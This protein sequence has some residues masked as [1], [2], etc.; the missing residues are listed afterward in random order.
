M[1]AD[2]VIV[3]EP[4]PGFRERHP[5]SHLSPVE[6]PGVAGKEAWV[7]ILGSSLETVSLDINYCHLAAASRTV[8]D[9]TSVVVYGSVLPW[10]SARTH[11]PDVYGELKRSFI[12]IFETALSEQ[13]ADMRELRLRYPDD[14]LV[15]AGDF[16]HTLMGRALSRN[17]SAMLKSAV[18][19][20][21]LKATNAAAPHRKAGM[22]ALDL[23]CVERAW[24]CTAV[25][26]GYPLL[27]ERPLS[28]HCSYVAQ[29][30]R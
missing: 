20:L 8:L 15:W 25:D 26:T 11:A 3:T 30:S 10:L 2:L 14:A 9:E 6:R 1:R 13:V 7:A 27:A 5:T 4:G 18:E 21:G 29:V 19:G 22:N 12:E 23:I 17:A 16:N 28:D 24:K